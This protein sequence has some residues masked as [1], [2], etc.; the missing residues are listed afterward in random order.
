MVSQIV[1]H[2]VLD[3]QNVIVNGI[4]PGE[5]LVTQRDIV[6]AIAIENVNEVE[7]ARVRTANVVYLGVGDQK[8]IRQVVC[9][10]AVQVEGEGMYLI[11]HRIHRVG[12]GH[13]IQRCTAVGQRAS[14]N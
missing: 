6:T 13:R 11:V 9:Q 10:T 2:I 3:V 14:I 1:G 12:V 4:V 7:V 5:Q 8:L